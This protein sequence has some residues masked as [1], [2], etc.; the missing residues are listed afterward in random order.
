[1]LS[2]KLRC[3][4]HRAVLKKY[5][6]KLYSITQ[7]CKSYAANKTAG[8]TTFSGVLYALAYSE[9]HIMGTS[10]SLSVC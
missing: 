9:E 4:T 5:K 2:T 1:M 3:Q 10:I 7:I 8:I 6:Q